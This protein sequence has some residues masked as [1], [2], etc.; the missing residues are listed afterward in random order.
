ME[1][2]PRTRLSCFTSSRISF[3]AAAARGASVVSEGA[4]FSVAG[5]AFG[6][7]LTISSASSKVKAIGRETRTFPDL[8]LLLAAGF[9]AVFSSGVRA[10]S[11]LRAAFTFPRRAVAGSVRTPERVEILRGFFVFSAVLVAEAFAVAL[12]AV[13]ALAP[14]FAFAA[15]GLGLEL[16]VAGAVDLVAVFF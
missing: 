3:F 5:S 8:A 2:A 7:V 13:T 15:S 10:S 14:G 6:L 11:P 1:A 4:D 12:A 16:R 9:E